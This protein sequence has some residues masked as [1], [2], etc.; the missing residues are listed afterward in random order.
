MRAISLLVTMSMLDFYFV[1]REEQGRRWK[2]EQNRLF[3]KNYF[4][5][6]IY[7]DVRNTTR[8]SHAL[9][10]T[11]VLLHTQAPTPLLGLLLLRAY[12][13]LGALY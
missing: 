12:Y 4:Y 7:K 13:M 3:F 2:W 1:Y 6:D 9:C 5:S 8:V 11:C 10:S